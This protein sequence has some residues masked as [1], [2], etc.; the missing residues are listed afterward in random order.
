M[1]LE[2]LIMERKKR[3]KRK[4]KLTDDERKRQIKDWC[5]FY[6]RNWDIYAVERLGINLKLFQRVAIHLLGVSDIFFLMCSR[7]LSKSFMSA[8]AAFIQ[9]L[10]Y[11]NS[12]VVLT[13]TT[14]KTAKKMVTDK[15]EDE[16]CGRFS[17]VL[18]WMKE[19]KLIEFHYRDEEIVVN[20]NMND[21]WIRVLPSVDS[22]RGERATT[23]IFEECRLLKKLIVDSVFV[24]M[25]SAR[26]PAYRLK[27][28]YASDKR[29][30]ER[31]K[32]LYLTSTR[33]KHEW[34]WNAWKACVNN[35]FANTKLRYN[36]FAGDIFT[37]IFHG[38]KTQEDV[39]ADKAQMSDLEVR[40]E[41]LNEPQ[42][43]VEGSFYTLNM[44]NANRII[45]RPFLPPSIEEYVIDYARGTLPYFRDK[46]ED[47]IRA[48]YIDFAFSDTVNSDND[49]DNTVIGC[50]SG[51][52][53]E[54]FDKMLRNGE[55]METFSGGQ[56]DET[57]KRIRE[58]FFLYEADVILLDLR[59]GGEDRWQD[60]SKSYYHEELGIEMRGFGIYDDDDILRFFCDKSKAD[61]LR[62]RT[63]DD[64]AHHVVIPVV[65]TAE[66]NNNYHLAMKT[67]LQNH[68]MRFIE[69]ELTVKEKLA[70][71]PDFARLSSH[72]K[73]RRL[74]GHMQID[75]MV[76]DEAIKLQQVIN[77]GFVA[78]V[79]A[80]RNKRDRI[81][82]C[83]YANYFYYLKE[84][85]MIKKNQK[86]AYRVEDFRLWGNTN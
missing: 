6:R 29:L 79:A 73:M 10:L 26:V 60:L 56:K 38:F 37:S 58:L 83:E 20:F 15:M 24:P 8:L 77:K 82:A 63:V 59:N 16:L 39:D 71:D 78:L 11:P 53:N 34:F 35:V 32:I 64:N 52:P 30:V 42:G 68:T 69:D 41:L 62:E 4:R 13:A 27:P 76:I 23:L 33:Y 61:N 67:A 72:D 3:N 5:T 70:E 12:H 22:S 1:T 85:E 66:R 31:T 80:G 18:N 21:S 46:K 9:C 44:F 48:L 25:R 50:M 75:I 51:Y 55:Y 7:G 65:G 40:M 86:S 28:E 45:K 36:V 43:E 54:S 81:V 14:I 19:N 49:A 2:E 84:L 57:L 47:E 74:I 17:K